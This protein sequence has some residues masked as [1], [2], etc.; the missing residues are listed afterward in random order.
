MPSSQSWHLSNNKLLKQAA[1][2]SPLEQRAATPP[3]PNISPH[4]THEMCFANQGGQGGKIKATSGSDPS[5]EF[6]KWR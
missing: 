3:D 6:P 5:L 4:H 2:R 1:A